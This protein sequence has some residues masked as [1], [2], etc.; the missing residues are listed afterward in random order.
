MSH[1][2]REHLLPYEEIYL[3][4]DEPTVPKQ[5]QSRSTLH[6]IATGI[7]ILGGIF[8]VAFLQASM[9]VRMLPPNA[10]SQST[11]APL[12]SCGNSTAEA[13]SAGCVLDLIAGA[14][15]H[16]DCYDKELENEFLALSDW[17][18]F[19]DGDGKSELTLETIRATGGPDPY[20]TTKEYHQQ[21]CVFTWHKLHRAVMN[22]WPIDS[23]VGLYKHTH[24]CSLGL[25]Q[26][27]EMKVDAPYPSRFFH[28][29]TTCAMPETFLG[30][31]EE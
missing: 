18:W 14:W 22:G 30:V 6:W 20:H 16:P 10:E 4:K 3:E 1:Q 13:Q 17:Q 31:E 19:E 21:H 23:H 28:H 12:R 27:A 2:D 7:L 11:S 29:F 26:W 8:I 9:V 24:H 15:V 5:S 25:M